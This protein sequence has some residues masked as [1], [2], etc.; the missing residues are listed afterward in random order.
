MCSLIVALCGQLLRLLGGQTSF[1]NV[2]LSRRCETKVS[3]IVALR[4]TSN[5]RSIAPTFSTT[6]VCSN[7][8]RQRNSFSHCSFSL[9]LIVRCHKTQPQRVVCI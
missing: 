9:V 5:P 8:E 1:D 4:E 7:M 3:E 6:W 2:G